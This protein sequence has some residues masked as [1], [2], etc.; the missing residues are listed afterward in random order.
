[1][2][3]GEQGLGCCICVGSNMNTLSAS[4]SSSREDGTSQAQL[5]PA[6]PNPSHQLLEVALGRQRLDH[7]AASAR[8]LVDGLG[9]VPIGAALEQV[10]QLLRGRKLALLR[11]GRQWAEGRAEWCA[12]NAGRTRPLLGL[13]TCE[14]LTAAITV[15][16]DQTGNEQLP[17]PTFHQLS[18]SCFLFWLITKRPSS[19]LSSGLRADLVRMVPAGWGKQHGWA[20]VG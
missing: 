14:E 11:Q 13:C 19:T 8:L 2:G 5:T 6:D 15:A 12:M 3:A 18:S 10:A 9:G 1:M 16:G 20:H 17:L 4:S 7:L